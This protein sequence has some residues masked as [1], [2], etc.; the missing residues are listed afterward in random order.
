MTE[1][2]KLI[3]VYTTNFCGYCIRAKRLLEARG[4]PYDEINLAG[5]PEARRTLMTQTKL[6]TLPQIFVGETF[7]GGSDDLARIDRSGELQD[8]V[9]QARTD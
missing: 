2:P 9:Q 3:R 1:N 6:R 7:V 4:L 8:L 5:D